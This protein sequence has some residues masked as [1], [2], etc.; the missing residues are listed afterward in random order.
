LPEPGLW[1]YH[2]PLT[3]FSVSQRTLILRY[4]RALALPVYYFY[5]PV[6]SVSQRTL[7]ERNHRGLPSPYIIFHDRP[8]R[9]LSESYQWGNFPRVIQTCEP[10]FSRSV[11]PGVMLN[12]ETRAIG[13]QTVSRSTTGWAPSPAE[14]AETVR[15]PKERL[16]W[17][18][19]G[20]HWLVLFWTRSARKFHELFSL[21]Y[22]T[23]VWY[24]SL[25]VTKRYQKIRIVYAE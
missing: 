2:S 13:I 12:R 3:D 23:G 9:V 6:F 11:F 24:F 25:T 17:L 20:A 5:R 1:F 19:S 8:F 10:Y 4:H 22:R 16:P 15:S 14:P 7:I 18:N 21:A